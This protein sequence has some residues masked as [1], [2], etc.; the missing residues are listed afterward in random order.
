MLSCSEATI[1][2]DLVLLEESNTIQRH[3]GGASLLG[4][5]DASPHRPE[6][7]ESSGESRLGNLEWLKREIAKQAASLVYEAETIIINGG[8][9]TYFMAEFLENKNL[10]VITNSFSIAARMIETSQNTIIIPGGIIFPESR[11]ILNPFDS[12]FFNNYT[13]SKLFMSAAGLSDIGASNSDATRIRFEKSM[14]DS[15]D[16]LIILCD[17]SRFNRRGGLLLCDLESIDTIV[18]DAGITAQFQLMLED[19]GIKVLIVNT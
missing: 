13:P 7:A 18:T 17:S 11:S 6:L 8:S 9:T 2:R 14:I 12:D 4:R 16:E 3:W 10:K 1:R 19:A 5:D 15:A